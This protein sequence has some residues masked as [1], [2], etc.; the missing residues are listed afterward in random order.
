[1][2]V[3]HT[4]DAVDLSK[5]GNNDIHCSYQADT[6]TS[7]IKNFYC[8][9]KKSETSVYIYTHRTQ[10]HTN[11]LTHCTDNKHI[12]T[13]QNAGFCVSG[14][15]SMALCFLGG[16]AGRSTD[17]DLIFFPFFPKVLLLLCSVASVY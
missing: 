5:L 15:M 3:S 16:P 13:H 6:I 10:S 4:Q 1:M 12:S 7:I 9:K 11:T 14:S 17:F 8:S 2:I